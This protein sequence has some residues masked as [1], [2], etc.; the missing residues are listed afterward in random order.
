LFGG[1]H[2][3]QGRLIVRRHGARPFVQSAQRGERE[4]GALALVQV[5]L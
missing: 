5:N 1:A 3:W 2:R 4:Q